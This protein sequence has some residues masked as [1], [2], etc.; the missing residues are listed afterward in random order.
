MKIKV[1]A[2]I[3]LTVVVIVFGFTIHAW[4]DAC[5][6]SRVEC[7]EHDLWEGR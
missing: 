2:A 6:R 1:F 4:D 7:E 5:I 3:A